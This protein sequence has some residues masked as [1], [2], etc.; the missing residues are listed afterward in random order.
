MESS[1]VSESTKSM[2]NGK[3]QGFNL[4]ESG[5][6]INEIVPLNNQNLIKHVVESSSNFKHLTDLFEYSIDKHNVKL[7]ENGFI[8]VYDKTDGSIL[9]VRLEHFIKRDI[10]DYLSKLD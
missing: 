3:D 2:L 9:R 4:M 10:T 7:N 5:F 1:V 6:L 8:D